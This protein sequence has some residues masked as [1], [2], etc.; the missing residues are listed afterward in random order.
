MKVTGLFL[1]NVIDERKR[2]LE[3][4][5]KMIVEFENFKQFASKVMN[6]LDTDKNKN[7]YIN[8]KWQKN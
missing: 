2:S 1:N 4:N 8:D 7:K 5:K 3:E 6:K